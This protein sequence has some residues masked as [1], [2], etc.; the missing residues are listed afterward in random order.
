[1]SELAAAETLDLGVVPTGPCMRAEPP[2][3]ISELSVSLWLS[4]SIRL[5]GDRAHLISHLAG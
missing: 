5:S 2:V 1:M 3:M 4:G